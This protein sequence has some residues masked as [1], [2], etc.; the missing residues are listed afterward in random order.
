MQQQCQVGIDQLDDT[1][2]CINKAVIK[3][4]K[5]LLADA[6]FYPLHKSLNSTITQISHQPD[7]HLVFLFVSQLQWHSSPL[8]MYNFLLK[9]Y[10]P[11]IPTLW[12]NRQNES[13][14]GCLSIVQ[15]SLELWPFDST[16][17][18]EHSKDI[19]LIYFIA[20]VLLM[21]MCLCHLSCIFL[22]G[23]YVLTSYQVPRYF[24]FN[25][26]LNFIVTN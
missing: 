25:N 16:C 15:F 4:Q 22:T 21:C 10:I 24:F 13:V 9:L 12:E 6:H 2:A 23:Q 8:V 19:L 17:I 20:K 1:A 3:C 11:R 5:Y 14:T 18:G 26:L 7:S